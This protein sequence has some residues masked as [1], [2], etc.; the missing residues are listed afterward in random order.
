VTPFEQAMNFTMKYEV[1]PWWNP[2][3]PEVIAGLCS[4][5]DQKR[6][7]GYVNDPLDRGGETKYGI[8]KNSNANVDIVKLN[9]DE[10]KKIYEAK[11]WQVG[12]CNELP[13]KVAVAHFD[14]CVNHG[15]KKAIQ[16]LQRALGVSDDGDFGPATKTALGAALARENVLNKMIAERRR[17]F[18]AVVQNNPSQQRF[19]TGW[20]NRCDDLQRS[21]A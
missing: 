16:F 8:A 2:D 12:K 10:A 9:L 5:K 17:F 19:L 14:A 11:Y 15:P 6:K 18:S 13:G 20:M 3:D 4:T 7:T 21:L 1:G